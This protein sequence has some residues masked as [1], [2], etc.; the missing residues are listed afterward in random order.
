MAW[1][2]DIESRSV[3]DTLER[4]HKLWLN[5]YRG[6]NGSVH[7]TRETADVLALEILKDNPRIACVQ[8]DAVIGEGL[9]DDE[10]W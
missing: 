10:N 4:T 6:G 7:F 8:V 1:E 5:F 3:E 9:T 2:E